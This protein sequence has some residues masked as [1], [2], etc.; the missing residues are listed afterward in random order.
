[1]K[2]MTENGERWAGSAGHISMVRMVAQETDGA[3]LVGSIRI[4]PQP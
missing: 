4:N 1:M 2:M 3:G